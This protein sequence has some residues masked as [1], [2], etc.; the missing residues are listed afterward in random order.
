MLAEQYDTARIAVRQLDTKVAANQA[1]LARSTAAVAKASK[2]LQRYAVTAYLQGGD[3]TLSVVLGSSTD[4]VGQRQGYL[5]IASGRES[6]VLDE[7]RAAKSDQR[8]ASEQLA[9]AKDR[10]EQAQATVDT[11][12]KAVQGLVNQQQQLNDKVQGQL[13]TLVA[14]Y[15][16]QQRAIAEAKARAAAVAAAA[17]ARAA[18]PPAAPTKSTSTGSS[19]GTHDPTPSVDPTSGGGD[20]GSG[21]SGGGGGGGGGS[22]SPAPPPVGG[23]S[24]IAAAQTRLGDPY[25]WGAA[26]P[27]SFDCSG[28]VMW[29]YAQAG[30]GSLPHSSG[31]Q[32]AMSRHIS[33]SELQPGDLVFFGSP[34]HH[35]GI[36][37]GGGSMINALHSGAPVEYDSIYRL[38]ETPKAGRI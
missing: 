24:V 38:G 6:D 9:T 17:R 11:K 31:G 33:L 14:Q 28:L 22:T 26:G 32:Y 19:H 34:V 12:R 5:A 10:A 13:K 21:G 35:V 27:N 16:A 4:T 7:V 25:V 30:R 2:E 36:Y 15:Q 18:A 1:R 20:G 37:V 29:S 3:D 23:G 8:D